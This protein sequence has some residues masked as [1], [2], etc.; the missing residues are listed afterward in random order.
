MK[1]KFHC[2]LLSWLHT[3]YQSISFY[4]VLSKVVCKIVGESFL[5]CTPLIIHLLKYAMLVITINIKIYLSCMLNIVCTNMILTRSVVNP[6][7]LLRCSCMH[8]FMPDCQKKIIDFLLSF[9]VK[10]GWNKINRKWTKKERK[11]C[12]VEFTYRT[13][14]SNSRKLLYP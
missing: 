5:F 4:C 1:G 10:L 11:I 3:I 12:S 7:T 8:T 13:I 9:P 2:N 14:I 6:Y